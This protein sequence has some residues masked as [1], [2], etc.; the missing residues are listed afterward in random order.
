LF[1]KEGKTEMNAATAVQQMATPK[2]RLAAVAGELKAVD[3]SLRTLNQQK[4]TLENDAERARAALQIAEPSERAKRHFAHFQAVAAIEDQDAKITQEQE[5][6]DEIISRRTALEREIAENRKKAGEAD[7]QFD[8]LKNKRTEARNGLQIAKQSHQVQAAAMW[9]CVLAETEKP[10]DEALKTR[11][12]AWALCGVLIPADAPE[13]KRTYPPV[14]SPEQAAVDKLEREL[15]LLNVQT[16]QLEAAL[17]QAEKKLERFVERPLQDA[18]TEARLNLQPD[19]IIAQTRFSEAQNRDRMRV[20]QILAEL[21][22][23]RSRLVRVQT[24]LQAARSKRDSML[25][26]FAAADAR[27]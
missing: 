10:F 26:D 15:N 1:L 3:E 17:K 21:D 7:R 8:I 27:K 9:E 20:G 18:V 13:T 2:E 24:E 19:N 12:A 25:A 22:P 6:R 4:E 5:K 23:L 11:V 14:V 16:R